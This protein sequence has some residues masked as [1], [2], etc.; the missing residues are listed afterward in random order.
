MYD[1]RSWSTIEFSYRE[2]QES[3]RITEEYRNVPVQDRHLSIDEYEDIS[4]V[5]ISAAVQGSRYFDLENLDDFFLHQWTSLTRAQF[6]ELTEFIESNKNE[7]LAIFFIKLRKNLSFEDIGSLLN[8][9]VTTAR[10]RYNE[11]REGLRRFVDQTFGLKNISRADIVQHSTQIA[12]SLLGREGNSIF[13]LW[14]GTYIYQQKSSNFDYQRRSF[15]GQKS[16]NLYKPFLCVAPNGFIIDVFGPYSANESDGTILNDLVTNAEIVSEYFLQD[17]I[18]VLF[19]FVS[20]I[21]RL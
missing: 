21:S 10:R 11:A 4:N 19:V 15:S 9:S 1:I 7:A 14:D 12:N 17:D 18:F 5:F 13:A 6:E 3:V 20:G 8:L 16:R 2:A